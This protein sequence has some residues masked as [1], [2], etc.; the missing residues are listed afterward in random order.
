MKS[1]LN[2]TMDECTALIFCRK[3]GAL[4]G[5]ASGGNPEAGCM[6]RFEETDSEYTD[7]KDEAGCS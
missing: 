7:Q 4:P 1:E 3:R 6:E 2:A 5:F